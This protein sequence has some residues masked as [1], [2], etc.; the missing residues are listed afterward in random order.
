M[1]SLPPAFFSIFEY[2]DQDDLNKEG[3]TKAVID[4]TRH[5]YI[6]FGT[7]IKCVENFFIISEMY[8]QKYGE[9]Y[10]AIEQT[11]RKAYFDRVYTY[12]DK[13]DESK[14]EHVVEARKFTPQEITFAMEELR[15]H[16]EGT[17]EYERC[18]RIQKIYNILGEEVAF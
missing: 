18:A 6:I 9:K 7:V 10:Q 11:V 12:L 5:P 1:K 17:E 15:D 8:R 4:Y 2:D 3:F 13:F 14:Y 16:F